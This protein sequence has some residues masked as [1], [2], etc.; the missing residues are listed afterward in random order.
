MY[1]IIYVCV[2]Y[3]RSV[4]SAA[5]V[6]SVRQR[7]GFV[8]L[9]VCLFAHDALRRISECPRP[10]LPRGFGVVQAAEKKAAEAAAE[11][12]MAE[13]EKEAEAAAKKKNEADAAEKKKAAEAVRPLLCTKHVCAKL[14]VCMAQCAVVGHGVER[15]H[16]SGFTETAP[17]LHFAALVLRCALYAARCAPVLHFAR[18]AGPVCEVAR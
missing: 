9:F 8:C 17:A 7:H 3:A 1:I 14:A 5:H 11:L 6:L 12:K 13:A 16:C 15:Q 10:I 4:S 2:H 18:G